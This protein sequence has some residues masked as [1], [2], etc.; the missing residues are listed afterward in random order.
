MR[1]DTGILQ[2]KGRPDSQR[3]WIPSIAGSQRKDPRNAAAS[4]AL[5]PSPPLCPVGNEA[6]GDIS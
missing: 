2:V 6:P 4:S 3:L 1:R 5:V